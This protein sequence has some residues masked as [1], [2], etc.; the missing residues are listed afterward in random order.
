MK[1]GGYV[2]KPARWRLGAVP[3]AGAAALRTALGKL[4][5]NPAAAGVSSVVTAAGQVSTAAQQLFAA[6]GKDCPGT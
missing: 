2:I 5:A 6:V 3:C 1:P 4:A